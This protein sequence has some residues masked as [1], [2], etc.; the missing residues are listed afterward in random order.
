MRSCQHLNA[1]MH[2]VLYSQQARVMPAKFR[3]QAVCM[4]SLRTAV[5]CE[6]NQQRVMAGSGLHE[7]LIEKQETKLLPLKSVH[8]IE[9]KAL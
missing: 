9:Q 8:Q 1:H 2:E 3:I 4:M 5:S 6:Q 7:C